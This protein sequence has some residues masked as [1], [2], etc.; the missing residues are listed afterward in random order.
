MDKI[1]WILII[2]AGLLAF[3]V[4]YNLTN[5]NIS[6]RQRELATLKVLGFYDRETYDYIFRE[7]IILSVIG[8]LLGL[9]GGIFVYRAVIV[10]VEPEMILLPRNLAWVDYAGSA[11]LT[12]F[13]TW[14]VNQCLKPRIYNID[15][16]GSLK[17]VE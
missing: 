4:L 13:F 15:M 7:T 2:A 10:T 11:V 9:A 1:V 6:E 12:M 3:I 8:C 17:S 5:I 16:L 14:I